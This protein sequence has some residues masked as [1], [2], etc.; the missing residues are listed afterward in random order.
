MN[1]FASMIEFAGLLVLAIYIFCGQ[2]CS[3]SAVP[4]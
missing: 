4:Y 1:K 3:Y 2:L